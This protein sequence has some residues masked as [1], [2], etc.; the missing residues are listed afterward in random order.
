MGATGVALELLSAPQACSTRCCWQG[1]FVW[2]GWVAQ[3][4]LGK[5]VGTLLVGVA[6]WTAWQQ[7]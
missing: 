5:S 1:R 2:P 7:V 3:V 4:T 6:V